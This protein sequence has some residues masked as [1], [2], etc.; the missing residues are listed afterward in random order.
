MQSHPVR[1]YS[2]CNKHHGPPRRVLKPKDFFFLELVAIGVPGGKVFPQ[3]I[4]LPSPLPPLPYTSTPFPLLPH[5][6]SL[7]C[8]RQ[9]KCSSKISTFPQNSPGLN[10]QQVKQ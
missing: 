7:A 3:P 4:P 10:M 5:L 6:L 1:Y 2:H 9:E 8:S